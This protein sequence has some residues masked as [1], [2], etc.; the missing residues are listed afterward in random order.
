MKKIKWESLIILFIT[1]IVL[2]L[3][4][5][6][7]F[8][9]SINL[10]F[11]SNLIWISIAIIVFIIQFILEA[12]IIYLLIHQF[13]KKY[14]LLKTIKL[15]IITKFFNGI[16][17][18]ASGGQPFQIIE[19]K[20]DNVDYDKAMIV[21]VEDFILLQ[22]AVVIMSIVG[23]IIGYIFKVIDF[24]SFLWTMTIVGFAVNLLILLFVLFIS[25]K[26]NLAKKIGFSFI[27]FIYK[28]K[29]IKNLDKSINKWNDLCNKYYF[30]INTLEEDK[31]LLNKCIK[32]NI[33]Y[34]II[35]FT[36]PFFILKAVGYTNFNNIF[37]IT[38]LSL[39]VYLCGSFIPIPGGSFGIEY[40]YVNFFKAHIK[41]IYVDPSLIIWRSLTYYFPMLIGGIVYNLRKNKNGEDE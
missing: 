40:A 3:V 27:R 10:I 30:G 16:T 2:W 11:S 9:M 33:I 6:D 4:L 19:L 41:N 23:F 34:M 36:M 7:S 1:I 26:I 25:K 20:K 18:F 21:I 12:Y 39:Y 28:I 13:D 38:L 22:I 24:S 14:T 37:L 32:I 8:N 17:P 31:K 5:K 15:N 29:L 35:Y